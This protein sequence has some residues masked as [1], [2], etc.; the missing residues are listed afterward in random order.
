MDFLYT[1]GIPPRADNAGPTPRVWKV[2]EFS[3][4]RLV[5]AEPGSAPNQ[6]PAELGAARWRA[7]LALV[8]LPIR[9]DRAERLFSPGELDDLAPA[10]ARALAVAGPGDDLLILSTSRRGSG[11][12]TPLSVTARAFV[13]GGRLNLIVHDTRRDAYSDH[14][15]TQALP[16]FEF[17]RRS[18]ASAAVLRA[19]GNASLLRSDW[20]VWALDAPAA[21]AAPAASPSALPFQ[22]AP[23]APPAA[24][25]A[26]LATP[27]PVTAPAAAAPTPPAPAASRARD[28]AFYAEQGERLRGLQ[29]LRDAG[30]LSEE[31]F[32]RKRRAILDTL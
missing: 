8:E 18:G 17:G 10:L 19:D 20:V 9:S 24:A 4:L 21:G 13:Q 14:R 30:L 25:T 5:P 16:R 11:F 28:A 7:L 6:H 29:R 22:P 23:P 12:S 26:P 31:E 3:A 27:A 15:V 32:Q 1:T 2:G